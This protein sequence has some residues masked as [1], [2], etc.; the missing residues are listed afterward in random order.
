MKIKKHKIKGQLN[1]KIN[2]KKRLKKY[3]KKN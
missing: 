2:E 1:E 3:N